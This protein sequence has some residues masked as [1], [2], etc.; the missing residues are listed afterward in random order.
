MSTNE[1]I[2]S[3]KQQACRMMIKPAHASTCSIRRAIAS[4][5]C[6][7]LE[8]QDKIAARSKLVCFAGRHMY[9]AFLCTRPLYSLVILKYVKGEEVAFSALKNCHRDYYFRTSI[10]HDYVT[11]GP[12]GSQIKNKQKAHTEL[13]FNLSPIGPSK[14]L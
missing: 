14:T 1:R 3:S 7:H 9:T 4:K 2:R 13:S 11:S 12:P 5:Q 6:I 10:T 8:R